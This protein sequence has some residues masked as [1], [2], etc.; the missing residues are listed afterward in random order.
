MKNEQCPICYTTLEVKD[1]A[2]CDDCGHLEEEI[3]HFKKGMHQYN[4]YEIY[5]GLKLRLCNFC[6]VDFGA[7][8]SEYLGFSNDRQIGYKD[9]NFVATV[10]NP[11]TK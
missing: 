7:Y 10:S 2:P 5:H 8:D 3:Q 11:S 9:F 1:C 6:E 4:I